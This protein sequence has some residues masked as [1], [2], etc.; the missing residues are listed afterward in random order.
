MQLLFSNYSNLSQ[1][2]GDFYILQYKFPKYTSK[3]LDEYYELLYTRQ[4]TKELRGFEFSVVTHRG[5]IGNCNFCSLRLTSGD[6]IISRSQDSILREIKYITTLPHF[7]G[8]I[9]DLSA[10]S[11]NMYGMDCNL[12]YDCNK[13]CISCNKLDKSNKK[14]IELLQKAREVKGI[15]KIFIRSGIRYDLVTDDYLKELKHHISGTLKI[16]PEHVNP[17]VLGLMNKDKGNLKDFIERFNRLGCGELSFYFMTAHPGSSMNEAEELAKAIKK[18]TNTEQVQI[19]TPTPMTMSTCMYYTG[20][21][22][23]TKLPVYVPYTFAEKKE[24]KRVLMR[25]NKYSD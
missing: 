25:R 24:Q 16:A 10:P 21:N 7:K 19:F 14:L 1:K 4:V 15:K 5:C 17:N 12:Y 22:P 23:I 9:D 11:A 18:L 8:N 6:K 3:D 20:L 13:A 2:T